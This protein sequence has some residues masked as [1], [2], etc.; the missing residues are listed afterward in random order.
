MAFTPEEQQVIDRLKSDGR[1]TDEIAAYV[2]GI[3]MQA[4]STLHQQDMKKYFNTDTVGTVK[5]PMPGGEDLT[6]DITET[7]RGVTQRWAGP[8]GAFQF[9][10]EAGQAVQQAAVRE[11]GESFWGNVGQTFGQAG[12]S[13]LQIGGEYAGAAADTLGE[14]FIGAGKIVLT[15]EA[16]KSVANTFQQAI[17]PIANQPKVQQMV[18]DYEWLKENNPNKARDVRAALGG[19]N[20]LSEL[21]GY[22]TFKPVAGE[23]ASATSRAGRAVGNMLNPSSR[24][25]MR[26]ADVTPPVATPG[27]TPPAIP[28]AQTGEAVVTRIRDNVVNTADTV[29]RMARDE[30]IRLERIKN[31]DPVVADAYRANVPEKVIN[32]YVTAD[33]NTKPVYREL[34]EAYKSGDAETRVPEIYARIAGEQYKTVTNKLDDLGRQYDEAVQSLP[35]GKVDM[36]PAVDNVRTTLAQAGARFDDAGNLV[37]AGRAFTPDEAAWVKKL[38]DTVVRYGDDVTYPDLRTGDEVLSRINRE[39]YSQGVT[40]PRING[41]NLSTLMRD[42]IRTQL[43]QV[44]PEYR[45]LNNEYRDTINFKDALD[46]TIFDTGRKL[47]GVEIN[48]AE[49]TETNLRR[50]FSNAKSKTTYRAVADA[51]DDFARG[52]GYEGSR[53]SDV[54]RFHIE[55]QNVYPDEIPKASFGGGIRNMIGTFFAGQTDLRRTQEALEKMVGAGQATGAVKDVATKAGIAGVALVLMENTSED[56]TL[57]PG[58]FVALAALPAGQRREAIESGIKQA[59]KQGKKLKLTVADK[60]MVAEVLETYDT[61]PIDI[62]VNGKTMVADTNPDADFRLMQLKTKNQEGTFT[63]ADAIEARAL[64]EGR[65][66]IG[67]TPKK[68]QGATPSTNLTE[69]AKGKTLDELPED[70]TMVAKGN[71]MKGFIQSQ[72]DPLYEYKTGIGLKDDFVARSGVLDAIDDVGGV[73]NLHRGYIDPNKLTM[74]E[75]INTSVD[76]K[77]Y[78]RVLE[79]VQ[80]GERTP[81]VVDNAGLVFDGHHRLEAYN[82]IGLTEVPVVAP[83]SFDVNALTVK[84]LE[85]IW[86]KANAS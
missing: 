69:Q 57:M 26:G 60:R 4:P 11:E 23:I 80:A 49:A 22:G 14:L 24:Q 47:E 73:E 31:S 29:S 16:E 15:D 54:A 17:A 1:S 61:A 19:I 48:A 50:L 55:I 33:A 32:Q 64:L 2:G 78:Q 37:D 84:Q 6:G 35:G 74:T 38:Y 58:A 28:G 40:P 59:A 62:K 41:E 67:E 43:D 63:D 20:M 76:N 51:L 13:G 7:L 82:E 45:N 5:P 83:K 12:R 34:V 10:K 9:G 65:G 18:S 27:M 71:S 25:V 81:V 56:G 72:T 36:R 52:Q 39:A 3:R 85:D 42:S 86:K 75:S 53:L 21:V 77:R 46:K 30:R 70:L 66:A 8:D 68:A 79:E 44:L